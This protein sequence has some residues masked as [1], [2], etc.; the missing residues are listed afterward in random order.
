MGPESLTLNWCHSHP[1]GTCGA[2]PGSDSPGAVMRTI[3]RLPS[4]LLSVSRLKPVQLALLSA[5]SVSLRGYCNRS[6]DIWIATFSLRRWQ[7]VT[8]R[9]S[10]KSRLRRGGSILPP[11]FLARRPW[12]GERL[13]VCGRDARPRV[14]AAYLMMCMLSPIC[15]FRGERPACSAMLPLSWRTAGTGSLSLSAVQDYLAHKVKIPPQA[16]RG[17]LSIVIHVL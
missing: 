15:L 13:H 4:N 12:K 5:L 2:C 3:K 10:S 6:T 17:A 1:I 11:T 8:P 14:A 9:L 16:H 7:V